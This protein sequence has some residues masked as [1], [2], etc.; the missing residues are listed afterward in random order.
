MPAPIAVIA[1]G[2][3]LVLLPRD[4]PSPAGGHDILG[5]LTSTAAMLLLVYDLVS[6]PDRGWAAPLTRALFAAVIV[7]LTAFVHVERRVAHPLVRLSI[8]RK[9]SLVRANLA[10]I[11]L[12]GSYTAFQF[13][14]TLYLQSVL[15][16]EPLRMAFA[17]GF[18]SINVQ[19][20]AGVGD[21]EQGLAAGLVQTS[22]Q[23]GAA[24]VLAI[25]TAIITGDGRP[26][27]HSPADMLALYRPGLVFATLVAI[28]GLAVVLAALLFRHTG[29]GAHR[30]GAIP[31][32]GEADG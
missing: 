31:A 23:V 9:G 16:W 2:T 7:L 30:A 26:V 13:I 22:G 4:R 5:A 6:A 20:T 27:A 3:G 12:F 17:L 8:L 24:L 19:A 11:A 18:P 28:G 10:I 21:G 14:L 32:T 29:G 25:T 1:L 15:G